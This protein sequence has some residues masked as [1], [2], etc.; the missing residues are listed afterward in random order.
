M[1][2][3]SSH[4]KKTVCCSMGLFVALST[5]HFVQ[6][7]VALIDSRSSFLFASKLLRV[8][9]IPNDPPILE[10]QFWRENARL[11]THNFTSEVLNKLFKTY[12]ARSDR[13]TAA[14]RAV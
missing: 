13:S 14:G 3:S 5:L 2:N 8:F 11:A 6:N 9:E 10:M 12:P 4:L 7:F 1:S